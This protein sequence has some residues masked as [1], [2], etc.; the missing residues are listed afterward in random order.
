MNEGV[1]ILLARMDSHPEEFLSEY[2]PVAWN[3]EPRRW[4]RFMHMVASDNAFTGE[5]RQAVENKMHELKRNRFNTDVMDELMNGPERPE[6]RETAYDQYT[7]SY[8]VSN[9]T[10]TAEHLQYL[11]DQLECE[12][13]R[14]EMEK[15]RESAIAKA[16]RIGL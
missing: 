6:R 12:K 11:K 3:P 5:E 1:Q 4:D 10:M 13:L 14:M 15:A 7:Q 8:T 9:G 16:M 2:S